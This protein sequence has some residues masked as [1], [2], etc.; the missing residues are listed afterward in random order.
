MAKSGPETKLVKKMRDAGTERYGERLVTVKYHGSAYSEAGVS[1]LLC[2]LDGVFVACEVKAPESYKVKGQ[3]SVEKALA[4]G[5][6]DKQREFI[7]RV[8]RAGGVASVVATVEG[9]LET[10]ALAESEAC[11]N[12]PPAKMA[13]SEDPD[14]TDRD[15]TVMTKHGSKNPS[16]PDA[17]P[18]AP[19]GMSQKDLRIE[20]AEKHHVSMAESRVMSW[21]EQIRAVIA[22]RQD[23]EAEQVMAEH[24]GESVGEVEEALHDASV[25]D[26]QVAYDSL[27][28]EEKAA[29]EGMFI[30]T[31][32]L[33]DEK[34][35]L[36]FADLGEND[37][38][39]SYPG[40]MLADLSNDDLYDSI[41]NGTNEDDPHDD[42]GNRLTP[43]WVEPEPLFLG[44]PNSLDFVF[45]GHAGAG[46][47]GAERWM[48]CTASL[49]ATRRFLETL[50]PNQQ[51][52]FAGGTVAAR[53]GTTAHSAAEVEVGVLLGTISP[54]EAE[55]ALLDLTIMPES[56]AEAY[57]SDMADYITEYTDLAQTYIDAGHQVIVEARV[58]AAVP[59]TQPLS[60][61]EEVYW[62]AGSAD[63]VALPTETSRSLAVVDLKYGEGLDVDVESNPQIR[64]YALGVLSMLADPETGALPDI[65]DVDYYIVQPRMGGVKK[66]TESLDDLLTW[67]D[68]VLSPALTAALIGSEAGAVFA[69]SDL[70]CQWCPVRGSCPALVESRVTAGAALFDEVQAAEFAGID[71]TQG[72]SETDT[73]TDTRL[74]ELLRQVEDLVKIKDDLKEEAQR[75]LHRGGSVPGYQLVN[76]TPPRYWDEDA[77]QRFNAEDYPQLW[78]QPTMLTPTQAVKVL[79]EQ[80]SLADDVI[81]VPPKRPV[82]AREGDRR[83]TWTERAPEDMFSAVADDE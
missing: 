35:A 21:P 51:R 75:R 40:Q 43:E 32:P 33:S 62:I 58:E 17:R 70:A 76:Y 66:W 79:G 57:D 36:M 52:E 23:R 48:N 25:I 69:P 47:S 44:L 63:L 65:E 10:L 50:T 22:G 42:D 7:A 73:L 37:Q 9:F 59:L 24:E 19:G 27:T 64:I 49:G 1:D 5:P 82:I 77:D 3:P 74:G 8:N 45:D 4:E 20:L 41:V 80:A 83:K 11:C 55:N 61:G 71:T 39:V 78:K 54:E 67:R 46:P 81:V 34:A 72:F 53:Q 13:G 26:L 28:D 18:T 16:Y 6:T 12:T 29:A 56:G 60:D 31:E 68:E 15:E 2:T 14:P 38:V 30:E